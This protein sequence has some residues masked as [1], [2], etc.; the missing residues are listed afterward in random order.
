MDKRIGNGE[1]LR[2][3]LSYSERKRVSLDKSQLL[4]CLWLHRPEKLK[5][6]QDFGTTIFADIPRIDFRI[7]EMPI[8]LR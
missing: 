5:W 8:V 7:E 4:G 3:W 1:E 2:T 6:H